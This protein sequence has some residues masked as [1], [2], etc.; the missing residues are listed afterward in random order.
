MV[1]EESMLANNTLGVDELSSLLDRAIG[2][3]G[4]QESCEVAAHQVIRP[5]DEWTLQ[6]W[7][8]LGRNHDIIV[9]RVSRVH[10]SCSFLCVIQPI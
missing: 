4:A 8:A 6:Q 10:N 1:A 3:D 2:K 9:G 7:H 5:A